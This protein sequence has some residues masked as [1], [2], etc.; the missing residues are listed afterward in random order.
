MVKIK[1]PTAEEIRKAARLLSSDYV[2]KFNQTH[3]F[4]YL[5][6]EAWN[7]LVLGLQ[8]REPTTIFQ[9]MLAIR[10]IGIYIHRT[11][12][13]VDIQNSLVMLL[14]DQLR[15]GEVYGFN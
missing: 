3:S 1:Q 6:E 5:Y 2:L 13:N 7:T 14:I 9:T 15:G 10:M 11:L 12:L 8:D 4:V